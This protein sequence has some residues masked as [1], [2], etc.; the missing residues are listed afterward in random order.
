MFLSLIII[1]VFLSLPRDYDENS[2]LQ[3]ANDTIP[4]W[5]VVY[6]SVARGINR[7]KVINYYVEALG[8]TKQLEKLKKIRIT[9]NLR[10]NDVDIKIIRY[11]KYPNLYRKEMLQ[12]NIVIERQVFDGKKGQIINLKGNKLM[13]VIERRCMLV[14][15]MINPE[16]EAKKLQY[17]LWGTVRLDSIDAYCMQ[18]KRP[19]KLLDFFSAADSL[20]VMRIE[21]YTKAASTQT[22][23]LYTYYSDYREVKGIKFPHRITTKFNDDLFVYEIA[24][25]KVNT[26]TRAYNYMFKI[27]KY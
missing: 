19:R 11:K 3:I 2:H 27:E 20:K 22:D 14:E 26:G 1:S 10:I 6:S 21:L 12:N 13:D 4:E 15:A 16:E 5:G 25:I 17:K 7:N 9:H 24:E 8:G 18:S 23:T